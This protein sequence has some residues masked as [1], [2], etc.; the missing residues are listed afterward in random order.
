MNKAVMMTYDGRLY[1]KSTI[2]IPA[3]NTKSFSVEPSPI[4][5]HIYTVQGV[6]FLYMYVMCFCT[7]T[8]SR[9]VFEPYSDILYTISVALYFNRPERDVLLRIDNVC[10]G[11]L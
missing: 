10:C 8:L 6:S 3:V 2:H 5:V 7:V 4:S 11:F 9:P 1:G